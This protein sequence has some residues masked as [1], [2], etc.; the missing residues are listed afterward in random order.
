MSLSSL[1]KESVVLAM[2]EFDELGS[3]VFLHKYGFKKAKKYWLLFEGIKYPSK[4]IAGVAHGYATGSILYGSSFTGGEA[5]VGR[6]LRA[7]GFEVYVEPNNPDWNRDELVL[8]LELYSLSEGSTP[9]KTSRQV[10]ELSDYLK[11]IHAWLG[12]KAGG[13]FRNPNGVA[14][15]LMNFRAL[16]PTYTSQNKVGMKSGNKLEKSLWQE[17]FGRPEALREEARI[18]RAAYEALAVGEGASYSEDDVPYEASEGGLVFR[19]HK[20]YE[21]DRKIIALKKAKARKSGSLK[22]EVCSFDFGAT[23]GAL[24]DDY[25]EVHHVRPV[26]TLGAGYKTSLKDLA[27]LCAN[28]HRMAHRRRV[29]L[30]LEELKNSILP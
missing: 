16:D 26:S 21:R 29:T 20:R 10:I 17:F 24:G 27:L 9:G 28:C 22:C 14:L 5:S 4:A 25:I 13:T 6:R 15:K 1:T 2:K 3:E 30:T 8:A 19:L 7:L 12:T 18:I 23:Y 11:K